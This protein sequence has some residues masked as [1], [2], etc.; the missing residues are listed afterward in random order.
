VRGEAE[1]AP[2]PAI[3]E[4]EATRWRQD[5]RV[6]VQWRPHHPPINVPA[7]TGVTISP[8][9]PFP[10]AATP[11]SSATGEDEQVPVESM[12]GNFLVATPALT[13]PT[14]ERTVILLLEH[15]PTDGALG[16]VVNRPTGAPLADVVPAVED[17]ASEP[18]VLF[19]GG[20]VSRN[21]A[22]ALGIVA[23][24]VAGT[25][26]QGWSPV[27]P[28][29]ATVDLDHDPALLAASLRALRV[30]AGY[31]GWS[32]GQ[33]EGEIAE[34]S[35]Y[36]VDALPDDPFVHRPEQL[37]SAVLRRQGWPLAAAAHSPANPTL[38]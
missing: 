27:V 4:I 35:W 33:L 30:F 5:R 2:L 29:L 15:T 28:P 14:F 1:A 36:V 32:P 37:R 25:S 31:A 20:P 6:A 16:V 8:S 17:L 7:V 24:G 3:E 9:C 34:G 23:P 38:N 22:I 19:E 26:A 12:R 13:E 10:G 11:V 21:T 18:R